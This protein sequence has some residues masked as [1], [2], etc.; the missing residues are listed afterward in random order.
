MK[1]I[2]GLLIHDAEDIFAQNGSQL[3]D[4]LE[5][6]KSQGLVSKIGISVYGANQIKKT[7]DLFKP[8]IIQLPVNVLDQRL[9]QDGTINHLYS[10]GI[11]VHARSAFLQGLLLM[12]INELPKYFEP[13]IPLLSKW[14]TFCREQFIS[15]LQAALSFVS[16]LK[17]VSYALVGVQN[18]YQLKD[19]L[20]N[21]M[22][23]KSIKYDQFASD[24]LKLLDPS[25]WSKA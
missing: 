5:R 10:L 24:D 11:E 1:S 23:L 14:H 12:R 13:W 18:Q 16:G 3:V 7:L 15:P 21:S 9:V 4:A 19:I 25:T 22:T 17:G 6:I 8:D 2:Y 20:D